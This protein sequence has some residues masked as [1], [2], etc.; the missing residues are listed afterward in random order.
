[1]A[2]LSAYRKYSADPSKDLVEKIQKEC[3]ALVGPGTH[4]DPSVGNYISVPTIAGFKT[5]AE[6][7][8]SIAEYI[9]GQLYDA[10]A[11]DMSIKGNPAYAGHQ[12]FY[13]LSGNIAYGRTHPVHV[14]G[15]ASYL[16]EKAG[17]AGVASCMAANPV[18]VHFNSK[19]GTH[20]TF[21]QAY[22]LTPPDQFDKT[23]VGTEWKIGYEKMTTRDG[24]IEVF[25][26]KLP[27]LS[28]EELL[29]GDDKLQDKQVNESTPFPDKIWK[30][31]VVDEMVQVDG[32][33]APKGKRK[34]KMI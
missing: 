22:I 32:Y 20:T 8:P 18:G 33:T 16:V 29:H 1:L 15:L 3:P 23:A 27:K 12:C 4:Y 10:I 26:K 34:I 31:E 11:R 13:L 30:P 24:L 5:I 17:W 14:C 21:C 7:G 6:K 25:K 19:D 2:D 28:W 9:A